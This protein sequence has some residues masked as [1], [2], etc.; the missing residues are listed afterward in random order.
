MSGDPEHPWDGC[1]GH[2]SVTYCSQIPWQESQP[3]LPFCHSHNPRLAQLAVKPSGNA[4]ETSNNIFTSCTWKSPLHQHRVQC[5]AHKKMGTTKTQLCFMEGFSKPPNLLGKTRILDH[6]LEKPS[7]NHKT[8]THLPE[9]HHIP[10]GIAQ[11]KPICHHQVGR[12]QLL[13]M[14]YHQLSPMI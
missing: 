8:S 2:H 11:C 5:L 6:T 3:Q 7:M 4:S 10:V 14:G 12:Q 1:M 13:E 9:Y